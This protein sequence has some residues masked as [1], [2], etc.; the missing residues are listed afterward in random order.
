[1]AAPSR[2]SSPRD[3]HERPR[4]GEGTDAARR[5]RTHR[6]TPPE[7]D[8]LGLA[9]RSV[10]RAVISAARARLAPGGGGAQP[11]AVPAAER[12]ARARR[13]ARGGARGGGAADARDGDADARRARALGS[14]RASPLGDRPPRG[15]EPADR[16]RARADRG[17]ARCLAGALGA[18]ARRLRGDDLA[19]ATAVLSR[20]AEMFEQ[21]APEGDERSAAERAGWAFGTQEAALETRIPLLSSPPVAGAQRELAC[22]KQDGDLGQITKRTGPA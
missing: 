19:A 17:Q 3:A 9:F 20:L 14:R 11:R 7:L 6:R 1:M 12:A 10:V 15:G 21:G 13:A 2:A 8:E 18:R 5:G 16:A 22:A 4:R